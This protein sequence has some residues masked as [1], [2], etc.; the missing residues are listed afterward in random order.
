MLL[1]FDIE[2]M[3]T[4][5]S[6][7]IQSFADTIKPP[8]N[9]SKPETIAKWMEENK[10]QALKELVAKTSFDGLYGR[11]ACIA[12]K[13]ED[14]EVDSSLATDSEG[15][16]IERFYSSIPNG[17]ITFC[18]HNVAGFD[19]PFLKHRSIILGIKPPKSIM[20]AMNAKPWDSC[21]A[22]TMLMWSSDRDKRTSMDKL[23]RA[24]G[25]AG[26]GD[27]NGSM[28]AE[29]WPID[30]QRVIDYCKDDAIRTEAIYNRIAFL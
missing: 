6:E 18:G 30:P 4:N 7:I 27:F 16:A 15:D 24:F 3:P 20:Q 25:I 13:H 14:K 23:C 12:W 11:V 5:D 9:Y 28:V 10:E 17:Q 1:V 19:L 22:D 8:A 29:T 26:K 21:I 2:T